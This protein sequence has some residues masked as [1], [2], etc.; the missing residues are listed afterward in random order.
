MNLPCGHEKCQVFTVS[1]TLTERITHELRIDEILLAAFNTALYTMTGIENPCILLENHGRQDFTG[2]IDVSHTMGWFAAPYSVKLP[3]PGKNLKETLGNVKETLQKVPHEGI[4][5]KALWVNENRIPCISKIYLNYVGE[6]DRK[7]DLDIDPEIDV[8]NQFDLSLGAHIS[9]K[10]FYFNFTSKLPQDMITR[11][12]EDFT[13]A[14][15]ELH[16]L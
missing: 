12:I 14:L 13:A 3:Q 11:F 15:E 6:F 5:A 4:G 8:L 9:R 7:R 16:R 10:Q 1:E 2:N